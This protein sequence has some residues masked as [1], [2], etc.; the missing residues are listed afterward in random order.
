MPIIAEREDEQPLRDKAVKEDGIEK[1]GYESFRKEDIKSA[2][3]WL[4]RR[5]QA[6]SRYD[7]FQKMQ[8]IPVAEALPLLKEAFADAFPKEGMPAQKEPDEKAEEK[9]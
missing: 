4:K 2:V 9:T 6:Y 5:L 7:G 3:L 8:V 1:P